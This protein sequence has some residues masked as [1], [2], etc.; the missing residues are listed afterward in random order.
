MITVKGLYK[1]FKDFHA[2]KG[3]DM[4]VQKG[5]IYGFIGHNGAGKSTTMN[6][7][8][9]LSRP[10]K[11]Q[12]TVNGVA[13]T[14]IEHPG[15]L[16][17]GYL[18]E[19]PR[20]YSWMTTRET[21]AYLGGDIAGGRVNEMLEWVG[22]T[23]AAHRRVGGF[24]R[25]M[26][27]RLGVGAALVRDPALLILDEPSS[28]LD[29]EGRSDVLRLIAEMKQMGKTVLFSTHILSDV[30]RVCDRVGMIAEGSMIMEKTISQLQRDNIRPIFDI[31]SAVPWDPDVLSK[32]GELDVVLEITT[33]GNTLNVMTVDE[34]ESSKRL[35]RFF[36]DRNVPL[37]S[38]SLR[39]NNL[40]ELF[41]Q[42]VKPL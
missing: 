10:T 21:L 16:H 30:E 38:L 4:H 34:N 25:G 26:K 9:G 7:L 33:E 23:H 28:A 18:P 22:L 39:K 27:Q 11:G 20:F 32:L 19:D 15:D 6:I 12:C 13:L 40:E 17:I 14:D 8:A 31:T 36:A 29:P 1:N 41:L 35:L 42:E 37:R 2:L 24:S 3:V 5:E